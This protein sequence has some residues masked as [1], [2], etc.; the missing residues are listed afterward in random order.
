MF[1]NCL[2]RSTPETVGMLADRPRFYFWL[3][4]WCVPMIVPKLV[5]HICSDLGIFFILSSCA[6]P[7]STKWRSTSTFQSYSSVDLLSRLS[8]R[9][10]CSLGARP[11][12]LLTCSDRLFLI[13][14]GK[15][16]NL[17]LWSSNAQISDFGSS[18]PYDCNCS[19]INHEK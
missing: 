6:T 13:G 4:L 10:F 14:S 15:T 2:C 5:L 3:N 18:P 8:T 12:L 16:L 1:T 7:F 17:F 11:C 19:F 9:V